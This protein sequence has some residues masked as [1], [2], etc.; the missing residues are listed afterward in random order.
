MSN[1]PD[2]KDIRAELARRAKMSRS[3]RRFAEKRLIE[4]ANN[5]LYYGVKLTYSLEDIP[6]VRRKAGYSLWPR[7]G[8]NQ[9]D[10]GLRCPSC[11]VGVRIFYLY[12][13]FE[14]W[15]KLTEYQCGFC[16]HEWK[17]WDNT[18]D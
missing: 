11:R 17:V 13:E 7:V 6:P 18:Y 1:K 12:T 2:A 15:R 9:Y 8:L 14:P 10:A 3:R 5:L 16:G 4:V